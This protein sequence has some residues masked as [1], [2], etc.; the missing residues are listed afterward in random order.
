MV[1][2]Y[3]IYIYIHTCITYGETSL[4][5]YVS[6][7]WVGTNMNMAIYGTNVMC[8]YTYMIFTYIYIQ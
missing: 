8:V 3:M 5:E 4:Y 2:I 6:W 1:Y 7:L